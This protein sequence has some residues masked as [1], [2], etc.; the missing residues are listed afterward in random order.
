MPTSPTSKAETVFTPFVDDAAVQ[1]IGGLSF[2]NGTQRI[3]LHGSVD[4]TRDAA[5]LE[6]ARALQAVLTRIVD[7]LRAHDLPEAV[8]ELET[9]P[10][11]VK[12]PFA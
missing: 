2:E 6:R 1:T 10:E 4:L 3:A 5:G 8:A 12:N 9:P 11:M 7:A